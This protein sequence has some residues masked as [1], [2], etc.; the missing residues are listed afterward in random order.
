MRKLVPL[1]LIV[2]CVSTSVDDSRAAIRAVLDAQA[3]GWNRGDIAAYM[4]GYD[5]DDVTFVAGD[6]LTRGWQTVFD[7]Y[8]KKYDSR[9]KMGTLTFGDIEITMLGNDHAMANGTWRLVRAADQP[10]GRFTVILRR[11]REGW[12]VMHDHTS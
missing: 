3:A 11:T 12:R 1:L 4:A 6:S 8:A 7:R 5:R 10:N 9:E 2:S